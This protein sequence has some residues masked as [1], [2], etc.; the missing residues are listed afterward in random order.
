MKKLHIV[1][2]TGP[3]ARAVAAEVLRQGEAVRMV[4]RSGKME[5]APAGV[6]VAAADLTNPA[7]V[8]EVVKTGSVAY[9]CAQ[10]PYYRWVEEFP[11]MQNAIL[12]GLTGSG[13][14]LVLAENLYM[15]GDLEGQPIHEGLPYKA[16]TKKGKIRAEM[17]LAALDAH[18]LGN[19]WV[20]M[21]RGS[22]FFGPWALGS[23]MGERVFYPAIQG[24]SAQLTGR[25]DLPH[26][27]TYIGDF[28]KALVTLG[29][30]DLA[31]GQAWHVPND[32]PTITQGDFVRLV[33]NEL[34][35]PPKI[36][37][38]GKLM[39]RIG[40]LFVPEAKEMVEMMY[41]FEKPFIVDSSKFEKTFGWKATPLAE[42][43]RETVTWYKTHPEH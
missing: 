26:S 36:S 27:H 43:I 1:F 2:G 35:M 5:D 22:D 38:M 32:Q 17:A 29:S 8:R 37:S 18:R 33:F 42:S 16:H 15:Y 10:P 24:K 3:L 12:E 39:M 19:V 13:V 7:A 21:G 20:T 9:Q 23:S 34:G 40:G 41:E 30:S 25:T 11:G 28:G 6:E 31:G 4:N 14:R